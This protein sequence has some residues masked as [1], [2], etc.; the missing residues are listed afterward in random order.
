MCPMSP[1]SSM[2]PLDVAVVANNIRRRDGEGRVMLEIARALFERGHKVTA[3]SSTL[4]DELRELPGFGW[5]RVKGL[6]GPDMVRHFTFAMASTM[7]LRGK[8]FDVVCTM[9]PCGFTR[10]PVVIYSAFTQRGWQASWGGLR[11]DAY[12]RLHSASAKLL[13]TI[14]FKRA[15]GIMAIS[16]RVA[17]ELKPVTSTTATVEIVPGGADP[18]E[19]DHD[20]S[21]SRRAARSALGLDDAS[22]VIGLIGEFATGRKGLASLLAA[23][24]ARPGADEVVLVHGHGPVGK[25]RSRAMALGLDDRRLVFA[26]HQVPVADVLSAADVIVVPST[27]EPFSL[28]ALEAGTAGKPMVISDRAGAAPFFAEASA[29][30]TVD[31][32]DVGALR[33]AID[34]LAQDPDL[35]IQMGRRARDV[36]AGFTWQAVSSRAAEVIERVASASSGAR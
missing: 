24:A 12:R 25:A 32:L 21:G 29:A 8:R 23:A 11:P 28:V 31:P 27:Y 5:T 20:E 7:A 16:S 18:A 2:R 10:D 17:E 19:F 14:A 1:R 26:P 4:S 30:I 36:A 3:F 9:G 34:K 33:S 13:E 22:L 15:A 35:C 6:P